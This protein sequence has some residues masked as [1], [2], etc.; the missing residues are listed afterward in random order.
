MWP[1]VTIILMIMVKIITTWLYIWLQVGLKLIMT[2]KMTTQLV[3]L[4]WSNI[5]IWNNI[6]KFNL[7]WNGQTNV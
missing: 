2:K 6:T 1:L 5:W 3:Y 4:Y 7:V